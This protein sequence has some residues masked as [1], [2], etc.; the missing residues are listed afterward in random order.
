MNHSFT[1]SKMAAYVWAISRYDHYDNCIHHDVVINTSF[2]TE[3]ECTWR[4]KS[5]LPGASTT[6]YILSNQALF[7]TRPNFT[8]GLHQACVLNKGHVC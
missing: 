7:G 8:P 1:K 4:P 2:M 5:S 3:Y 6:E